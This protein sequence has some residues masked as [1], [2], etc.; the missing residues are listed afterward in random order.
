M[1]SVPVSGGKASDVISA[2]HHSIVGVI[3]E[4]WRAVFKCVSVNT[5]RPV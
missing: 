2:I 3:D 5:V 4:S 1:Q